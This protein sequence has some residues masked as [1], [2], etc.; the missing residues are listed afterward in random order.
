MILRRFEDVADE[1]VSHNPRVRKHVWLRNGESENITQVS[2]ATFPPGVSC[3][4]HS[5]DDMWELFLVDFGEV[6]FLINGEKMVLTAGDAV[7]IE[8]REVH[9]VK[10]CSPI[11][12]KLTVMSWTQSA[13]VH[14]AQ[15]DIS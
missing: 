7:L 13:R 12:A 15:A 10:N 9:V 14:P 5:H 6:T 8:P 4:A 2:R 3:E 11:Y 1:P